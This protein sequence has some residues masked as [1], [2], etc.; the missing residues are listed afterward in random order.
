MIFVLW[1]FLSKQ[2]KEEDNSLLESFIFSSLLLY[3]EEKWTHFEEF[4]ESD[5]RKLISNDSPESTKETTKFT[6]NTKYKS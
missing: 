3:M 2:N 6:V 5:I 1:S 4:S